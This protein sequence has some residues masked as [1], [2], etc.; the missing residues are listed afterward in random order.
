MC[1]RSEFV[2]DAL[3]EASDL[4]GDVAFADAEDF[5]DLALWPLVEVEQQQRAVQRRLAGDEALQQAQP[6]FAFGIG[7]IAVG[8]VVHA[9]VQ[10]HRVVPTPQFQVA[11]VADRH[12][13]RPGD[14]LFAWSGSL[15]LHRW[16]RDEAIVNQHIF[17]VIPGD[18]VPTWVVWHAIGGLLDHFKGIAADKATTMGHIQR[19]H[20]DEPVALPTPEAVER[21]DAEMSGLWHSALA[22]ERENLALIAT[23]DALLPA[24]MSGALRVRDAEALAAV[25]T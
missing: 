5:G 10:R 9:F 14:I 8:H 21:A 2:A 18:H 13:A 24:L 7:G 3:L 4:G 23:R 6:L 19:H 1:V 22:A 12:V 16:F 25:L 15:T 11:Q 20:L 17:K